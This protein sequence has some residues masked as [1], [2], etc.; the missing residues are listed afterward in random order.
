M[1]DQFYDQLK[2]TYN[3]TV[4]MFWNQCCINFAAMRKLINSLL[5]SFLIDANADPL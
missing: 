5:T 2:M 4:E 1:V 3:S